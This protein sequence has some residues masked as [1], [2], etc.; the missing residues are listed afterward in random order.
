MSNQRKR[1]KKRT[2]QVRTKTSLDQ[3]ARKEFK[4]RSDLV[5]LLAKKQD[6]QTAAILRLMELRGSKLYE[7]ALTLLAEQQHAQRLT[8]KLVLRAAGDYVAEEFGRIADERRN[9]TSKEAHEGNEDSDEPL[10][11]TSGDGG[12]ER[13]QASEGEGG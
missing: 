5:E 8:M 11:D 1:R 7:Q 6:E 3:Q 12:E 9:D 4:K 13:H 2:V 10:D